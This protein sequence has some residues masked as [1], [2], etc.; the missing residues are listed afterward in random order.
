MSNRYLKLGLESSFG[1]GD[2]ILQAVRATEFS[3]SVDHNV[4]YLEDFETFNPYDAE[5]GTISIGDSFT[6]YAIKGQIND[7][8]EA[9]F[10][11]ETYDGE[12]SYS[13]SVPKSLQ[14]EVG[15]EDNVA[16]NLKGV[17]LTSVELSFDVK[18]VMKFTGNYIAKSIEEVTFSAATPSAGRPYIIW[19]TSIS[20]GGTTLKAKEFSMT[21]NR[22]IDED[23]YVIGSRYLDGISVGS[24]EVSGSVTLEASQVAE[25]KRALFGSTTATS[26]QDTPTMA[27]IQIVAK[28]SDGA[29]T[30]TIDIPAAIY[31]KGTLGVTA[32]EP[33]SK[34]FDWRLIGDD[35]TVTVTE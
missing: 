13:L 11:T 19:N 18:D 26:P 7:V 10:G 5:Y 21:I 34:S 15:T 9:L 12:Y 4:I 8:L 3:I 30:M 16:Y 28:T 1:A 23:N 17:L 33:L 24:T 31:P 2:A 29:D 27:N 14:V 20:V 22:G 6:M 32:K 35:I 25:L